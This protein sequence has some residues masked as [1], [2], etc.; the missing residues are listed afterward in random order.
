MKT[1][2]ISGLIM[3]PLLAVVYLGGYPLIL[4]CFLVGILGVKE[5]YKGFESLDI[6]PSYTIAYGAAAV[7]YAIHLFSGFGGV[8]QGSRNTLYMLWFFLS[9][10]F[11]LLYLF[12]IEKRRLEDG[13]ASIAGIFYVI[14]FSYHVALID[15]LRTGLNDYHLMVWLVF[16]TA[17]G[18]D[19]MAYFSGSFFGKHKLCPAI[20]PK[21]TIE[22]SVGGTLGSMVLCGLFGYFV[23][24]DLLV[25]CVIIGF[26]GGIVSQ[27]GDLAASIFKRKMGIKDYGNLIPGHGGIMDRFDSVLFTAPLVYYYIMLV[28]VQNI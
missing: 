1:R 15:E 18:T 25:H 10:L 6:Y 24:P 16:L 7:L 8:L 5:F 14:F 23:M 13:M 17:F 12:Q 21:K 28:L 11:S 4:A 9:I 26:L 20:S 3:L 27:L 19:I 22:G 2:V